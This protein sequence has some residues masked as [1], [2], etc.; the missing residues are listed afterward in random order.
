MILIIAKLIPNP[1]PPMHPTSRE[2]EKRGVN[3]NPNLLVKI[4]NPMLDVCKPLISL[5]KYLISKC[6]IDMRMFFHKIWET[7]YP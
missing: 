1:H 6:N 3:P 5:I 7:R 2:I 4:C